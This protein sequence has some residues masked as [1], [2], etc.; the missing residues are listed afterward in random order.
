LSRYKKEG[1]VKKISADKII[2]D[3][4]IKRWGTRPVA[5]VLPE[6]CAAVI[7]TIVDRGTPAQAHTAFEQLRRIF[8][9]A[10]GTNQFGITASPVATLRPSDLIGEKVIRDRVLTDG[11]L[12]AIW[13]AASGGYVS[14]KK[15]GA[16]L[17]ALP[18]G[19]EMSYPYGPLIRAMILTGQREREISDMQWS[20][21]DFD[22]KIWTIPGS[23][24]KGEHGSHIV[25]LAP[26]ML[27]LLQAL[28]HFAGGDFVFST[29]G[30]QKAVN[31]FSSAKERIDELSG[32]T[33]WKFHDLRRTA[34]THF[35]ALPVQD[36][37]RELIIAHAQQGIKRVYDLFAYLDE[38]RECLT[39]WENRLRGIIS[40]KPPAGVAH[41]KEARATRGVA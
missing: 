41:L 23:R 24:M 40:P 32:V 26:D 1:L 9:W 36:T 27:A 22:R 5:D 28:P 7:R 38:K 29:T 10:I 19:P 6:E 17:R 4:F 30:G 25:P 39:L 18:D 21:I 14:P 3:E 35:S 34:R 2:R 31:G 37:V 16:R 13:K 20:E 12:R 33:G 11:E 15:P 8:S